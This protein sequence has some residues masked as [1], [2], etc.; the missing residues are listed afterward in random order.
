VKEPG[1]GVVRVRVTSDSPIQG[2]EIG[3]SY[4]PQALLPIAVRRGADLPA[5]A[6]IHANLSPQI[7]CSGA[8][9]VSAG[10]TV[11]WI[12]SST[13]GVLT[14]AGTHELLEIDFAPSYSQFVDGCFPI[15]FVACLG[16]PT[17][18]VSNILT[19]ADGKSLLV[20]AVDGEACVRRRPAFRRGDANGDGR[21][22]IS[23]P[24]TI[25]RCLF[26][27][28][29]C[30]LCAD[31]GD[32]NDDGFMNIADPSYL[33]NWRFLAGPQP[34]LP[35]PECGADVTADGLRECDEFPDCQ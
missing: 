5:E 7:S 2:G 16:A 9:A 32:A 31:A 28:S 25:L 34:P 29:N 21:F 23:D 33:L 13:G 22:D 26:L 11:G 4:D 30:A 24:I 14:P 15:G 19:D 10:V 6:E 3:L 8:P 35:F 20:A 18:P 27:E 12:N 17:A 1:T